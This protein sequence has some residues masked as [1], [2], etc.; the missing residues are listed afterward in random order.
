MSHK[1][2]ERDVTNAVTP[3]AR[4]GAQTMQ[5]SP[6]AMLG[7]LGFIHVQEEVTGRFKQGV[8]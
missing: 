7:M 5:S 4:P 2:P 6:F 8:R 3:L 1:L